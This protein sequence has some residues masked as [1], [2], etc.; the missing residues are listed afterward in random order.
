MTKIPSVF[1]ALALCACSMAQSTLIDHPGD[2]SCTMDGG[3]YYL[4]R[5]M[6]KV[7]VH[8]ATPSQEELGGTRYLLERVTASV[9]QD[10]RYGYCLDFLKSPTS[11][12]TFV[13]SRNADLL[14]QRVTSVADDKTKEITLKKE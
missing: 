14:L 2:M 11:E 7:V 5:T 6:V 8:E 9:R 12:D 4:P 13:V 3:T 1:L 10:R